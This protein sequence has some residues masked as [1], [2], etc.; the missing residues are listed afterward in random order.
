MG[1]AFRRASGR[2]RAPPDP[3]PSRVT[4]RRPPVTSTEKVEISNTTTTN[5]NSLGSA[6]IE[7]Y[8][9]I[10]SL[11]PEAKMHKDLWAIEISRTTTTYVLAFIFLDGT[12]QLCISS[13]FAIFPLLTE[14]GAPRINPDNVLEER[15]TQYDAMLSQMVGRIKSKP[16][17]KL[18][19]GE[20]PVVE[21]YNRPMPKLRNTKPDSG[22]YEERAVAPGTLNVAQLRH[23][24]LMYQGKADDHEGPMNIQ[25]IAEKFRL[26]VAQVQRILQFLSLPTEDN[27]KQKGHR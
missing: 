23:I 8:A 27:N 2:I 5:Q 21:R 7:L 16:G 19:T 24:I 10:Y 4:D 9:R 20:A 6:Q 14:D 15:D 11:N 12:Y 18:E 22:R 13:P 26:E 17:G 25:Q 3:P 1:Q